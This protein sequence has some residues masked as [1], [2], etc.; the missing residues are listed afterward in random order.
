MLRVRSWHMVRM[1]RYKRDLP[2]HEYY[3]AFQA[4]LGMLR[5]AKECY[6][7]GDLKGLR[8]VNKDINYYIEPWAVTVWYALHPKKKV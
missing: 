6:Q 5:R 7:K 4:S 1:K 3:I 2:D 8:Y